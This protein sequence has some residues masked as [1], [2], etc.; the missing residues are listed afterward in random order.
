MKNTLIALAVIII[1]A[2]GGYYFFFMRG[3]GGGAQEELA[4]PQANTLA[5]STATST[6]TMVQN[7]KTTVIGKSVESRDIVAY[8]FGSGEREI[9]FV[10]GIHGGYSWNTALLAY[11]L[12]KYL[13]T[14]PSA[15]PAGVKVTV[16]PVL[17]PDGLNKVVDADGPF[18]AADVSTSQSEQIAG[19]FNANEVDLNRNFDCDWQKTGK[20]QSKD[21]SGGA[22]AFSEPETAA[23]RGYIASHRPVAA[24][25][26][27]SSAGGV[28]AS[29]C[30]NSVAPE[31][32]ALMKAYADASKYPA[33]ESFDFYATTGDMVNWLAK[34]NIPGI[35]VLL[36]DHKNIE[37]EKN[38]AGIDALLQLYAQS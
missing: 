11:E 24:V 28:F 14:N 22:A 8:H 35:S 5:T 10:G 20:W 30:H 1:I 15:V 3:L 27:Y 21:V 26:W 34:E 36:T 13:E 12:V 37:W 4:P 17:N 2:L 31:T 32:A 16:V 9:L 6:D 19:R 29:S 38:K 18:A 23:V 25:V 33:H 7:E